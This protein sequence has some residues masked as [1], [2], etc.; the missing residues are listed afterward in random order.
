MALDERVDPA[1]KPAVFVAESVDQKVFAEIGNTRLDIL[2][3]VLGVL[4]L[5]AKSDYS[6]V[7]LREEALDFLDFLF[8]T[9]LHMSGGLLLFGTALHMSGGLLLFGTALH[10]SGGLL[11]TGRRCKRKHAACRDARGRR[12]WKGGGSNYGDLLVAVLVARVFQLLSKSLRL[13]QARRG[14][15][16]GGVERAWVKVLMGPVGG[17]RNRVCRIDTQHQ[18]FPTGRRGNFFGLAASGVHDGEMKN[19]RFL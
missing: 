12:Y 3:H 10:M 8:G 18:T 17:I 6:V 5:V 1:K 11:F 7:G 2:K 9:A 15:W 16:E 14:R 13:Q 19:E 4:E